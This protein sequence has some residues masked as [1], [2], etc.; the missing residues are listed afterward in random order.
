MCQTCLQIPSWIPQK[1]LNYIESMLQVDYGHK[2]Y[3]DRYAACLEIKS[4][5]LSGKIGDNYQVIKKG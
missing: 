5:I 1:P 3:Q 4:D 2:E